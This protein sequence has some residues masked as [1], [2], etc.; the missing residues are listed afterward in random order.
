MYSKRRRVMTNSVFFFS[1]S[2]MT[3]WY[4]PCDYPSAL[5][6]YCIAFNGQRRGRAVKSS[7]DYPQPFNFAIGYFGD[8]PKSSR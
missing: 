8:G 1:D 2:S 4:I 6:F 7:H 5:P 3:P